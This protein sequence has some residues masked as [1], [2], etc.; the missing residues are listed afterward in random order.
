AVP[1]REDDDRNGLG[2][3]GFLELPQQFEPIDARQS[4]V[5]ENQIEALFT[6]QFQTRGG[7]CRTSGA[8]SASGKTT[9]QDPRHV[10]I[11]FYQQDLGREQ[12]HSLAFSLLAIWF[13]S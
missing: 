7:G 1:G 3:R 12:I 5:K 2:F 4:K 13:A 6:R 8:N 9:R 11:V 10:R